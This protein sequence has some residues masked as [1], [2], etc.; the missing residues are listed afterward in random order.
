MPYNQLST[1]GDVIRSLFSHRNPG[2]C[3]NSRQ[4]TEYQVILG[5]DMGSIS[6]IKNL[7]ITNKIRNRYS[8]DS[9]KAFRATGFWNLGEGIIEIQDI[10]DVMHCTKCFEKDVS[11]DNCKFE[12]NS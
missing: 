8:T 10:F 3:T 7:S 5:F 2:S 12:V 11:R 1:Y 4:M 6:I 9:N